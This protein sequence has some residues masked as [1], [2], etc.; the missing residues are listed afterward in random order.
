MR[1]SRSPIP[2]SFAQTQ[3]PPRRE[4]AARLLAFVT[5]AVMATGRVFREDEL[6]DAVVHDF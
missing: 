4:Q 3:R 6:Y 5:D 1:S 2:C